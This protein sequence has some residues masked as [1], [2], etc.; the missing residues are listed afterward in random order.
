[1]IWGQRVEAIRALPEYGESPAPVYEA[2]LSY[3]H[4][5]TR[6]TWKSK[7][8]GRRLG[9]YWF[10]GGEPCSMRAAMRLDVLERA[11]AMRAQAAGAAEP[12]ELPRVSTAVSVGTYERPPLVIDEERD[13]GPTPHFR[14]LPHADIT[15]G[16]ASE[17]YIRMMREGS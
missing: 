16:M 5:F 1:M 12:P 3:V 9:W 7:V 8:S 14:D 4:W 10:P 6:H 15:G 13:M 17:D 2:T 11:L